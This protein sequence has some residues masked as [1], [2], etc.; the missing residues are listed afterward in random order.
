MAIESKYKYEKVFNRFSV[1]PFDEDTFLIAVR[2][3][4]F[5]AL[6]F[7]ES[8]KAIIKKCLTDGLVV[9]DSSAPITFTLTDKGKAYLNLLQL[10]E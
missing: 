7:L 4:K 8:E 2:D 3:D 6:G 5:I 9:I 1:M 10:C